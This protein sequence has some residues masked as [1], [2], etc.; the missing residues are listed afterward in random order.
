M[1]EKLG[2][3]FNTLFVAYIQFDRNYGTEMNLHNNMG[4]GTF[5]DRNFKVR[6]EGSSTPSTPDTVLI[7][8][9]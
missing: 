8:V 1:V 6:Q 4:Y 7:L 2:T 5:E 9:C 3:F